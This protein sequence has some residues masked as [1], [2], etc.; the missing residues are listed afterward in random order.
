MYIFKRIRT[1]VDPL[2]PVDS[3]R[4]LLH[5]FSDFPIFALK[6]RYFEPG[7]SSLF[8]DDIASEEGSILLAFDVVSQ[9]ELGE[10]DLV[11]MAEDSDSID[12]EDIIFREFQLPGKFSVVSHYHESLGHVVQS[13]HADYVQVLLQLKTDVFVNSRPFQGVV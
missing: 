6:H 11:E 3:K 9:F 7:V 1:V 10:F 12:S 5:D 4:L 13:A 2:E 8:I